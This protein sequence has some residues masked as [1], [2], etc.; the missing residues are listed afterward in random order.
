MNIFKLY[1]AAANFERQTMRL[2]KNTKLSAIDYAILPAKL[3]QGDPFATMDQRSTQDKDL[4]YDAAKALNEINGDDSEVDPATAHYQFL[5][6]QQAKNVLELK[7]LRTTMRAMRDDF[8]Q[9]MDK[10]K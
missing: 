6:I 5:D 8:Q 4:G 7:S 9:F 3:A 10:G 1:I 2:N